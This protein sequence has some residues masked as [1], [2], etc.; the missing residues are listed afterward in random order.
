MSKWIRDIIIFTSEKSKINVLA[1]LHGYE[2]ICGKSQDDKRC[3]VYLIDP[4]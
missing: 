3:R 2:E 4:Y 1:I